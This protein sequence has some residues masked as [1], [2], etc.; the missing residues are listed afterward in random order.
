MIWDRPLF[1]VIP[2]L[3]WLAL[4]WFLSFWAGYKLIADRYFYGRRPIAIVMHDYRLRWMERMLARENRMSDVQILGAYVRSAALFISV[5]LL[6]IAGMVGVLGQIENLQGLVSDFAI[7]A[8]P[9]RQLMEFRVLVML[10][11]F[12]YAFFKFAWSL[13]QFSYSL[14]VIGA[15]PMPGDVTG[16]FKDDFAPRAAEV[17]SRAQA[18]FNRALRGYYFAVALLP[19]FVDPLLLIVSTLGVVAVL[20]RIDFRSVTLKRLGEGTGPSKAP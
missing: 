7:S 3:D 17:I 12:V 13:R 8:P 20:Y 1:D 16:D 19:W 9:S 4:T 15:A 14:V 10:A 18:N 5:T 11:I 2:L 6:I